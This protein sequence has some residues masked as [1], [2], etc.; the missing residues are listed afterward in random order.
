MYEDP[1]NPDLLFVGNDTG[2][3]VSIDGGARWVKM[4]NNMPNIPV[5]DLL[6]HPRDNDL[7][8]GSYGRDLWIS[9]HRAAAGA[10]PRRARPKTV[11]LFKVEPTVQ[12]ITWSVRGQRLPVRPAPSPDTES[13]PAAW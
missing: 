12:R 13:R 7:V 2:V 11:H 4:N 6:V 9:E 10:D 1:K 3:F 8:L 5:Q